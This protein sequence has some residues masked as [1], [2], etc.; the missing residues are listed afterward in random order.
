MHR[1][2]VVWAVLAI[3]LATGGSAQAREPDIQQHELSG[4]IDIAV[5][6]GGNAALFDALY[7]FS[8]EGI[9]RNDEDTPPVLRRFLI[10]P[11]S[12]SLHVTQNGGTREAILTGTAAIE[13]NPFQGAV[14]LR[15]EGGVGRH[16]TIYAEPALEFGYY[17][18]TVYGEAGFR[19]VNSLQL[20]VFYKGEPVLKEDRD[21]MTG[22]Q[23]DRSGLESTFGATATFVTPN[24]RIF[25][26][27]TGF[28]HVADWTYSPEF[29][30]GKVT[31]RGF[32]GTARIAYLASMTTTLQFRG[33]VNRDHWVDGRVADNATPGF[34]VDRQVWTATGDADLIYWYLGRY[35]FRLSLGGGY[36]GAP[37]VY[38]SK[39][40]GLFDLGGGVMVR[41]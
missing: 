11:S 37:P 8:P 14:Y 23:A 25:A 34:D 28:G 22:A 21:D 4:E 10:H 29:N 31:V 1:V 26:T 19:P 17:F 24:D 6:T 5:Q 9:D 32:G 41:F 30:G 13:L 35:G 18:A 20:G 36:A 3:V 40:T 7:T 2:A 15:A 27:F 12:V 39:A 33:S 16:L 38:N